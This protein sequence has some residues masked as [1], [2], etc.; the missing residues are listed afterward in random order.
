MSIDA[1]IK[2]P[3]AFDFYQAVYILQR[4]LTGEKQQFR[5]VGFDS[6]P[7]HELIRFKSEQHLGFPGQA[8]AAIKQAGTDEQDNISVDMLVSFMGLTGP[9]GIL[10]RHY[11]ELILQR[12]KFKDTGMRDFYDVF[13]HRLISLFY[14]AWEKYRF[15]INFQNANYQGENGTK[16]NDKSQSDPFSQV[17]ARL[18]GGEG[19]NQ[20]YAGLFSKKIR[21]SD[22]LQQILSEFTRAKVRIEQF[23][24]KWQYLPGSEQTRLGSRQQPEGQYARLGLDASIGSR[25]WDINSSIAIH[26]TPE[27]GQEVKDFLPGESSAELVKQVIKRYLG[28]AVKVKILLHIKQRDV[29][30]A[31][32]S[33]AGVPLGMGCGLLSRVEKEN[34]PCTLSLS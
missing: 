10:P 24:G 19:F 23:Q 30:P 25:V 8:I 27:A 3:A 5:K 32:L 22:G 26:L 11:S 33:G 7:K 34:K 4:Q 13:N 16:N 17:L 31:Q 1:L 6:L 18:S 28:N 29:P 15:A 14:R 12:L 9:S 2:D 20:Y 21:S